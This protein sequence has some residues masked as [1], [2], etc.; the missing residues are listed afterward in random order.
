[1]LQSKFQLVRRYTAKRSEFARIA[2]IYTEAAAERMDQM[3]GLDDGRRVSAA[4]ETFEEAKKRERLFPR[5]VSPPPRAEA[6]EGC[7]RDKTKRA[8]C[9]D[10]AGFRPK[11]KHG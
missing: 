5:P 4:L 1:M 11:P 3:K 7:S 6:G 9:S 2:A 8:K 10:P